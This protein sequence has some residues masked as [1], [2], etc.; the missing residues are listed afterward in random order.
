MVIR[1]L[2][3]DDSAFMRRLLTEMIKGFPGFEVAGIAKNG[4]EA[5][6]QVN[7]LKPD[8]VTLDVEMPIMDGLQALNEIMRTYPTPV[9][10]VS[11]LTQEG[12]DAT[13]Q[14]LLL[15]AVD[16]IGKPTG[17]ISLELVQKQE[18]LQAKLKAAASSRR[19]VRKWGVESPS[20]TTVSKP[21]VTKAPRLPSRQ[22]SKSITSICAIGTSTGGPKALETVI[23]SLP[24]ELDV[25]IV[26][27][28][29][30]PAK[31]TA[32]LAQRLNQLSK[33]HVMEASHHQRLEPGC[34]YIAPGGKHMEIIA[35]GMSDFR[36]MIQEQNAVNGHRPSVEVM[37][38]SV[39]R[40]KGLHKT[41]VI[42]TG[43]GADGAKAMQ[44]AKQSNPLA[45][46]VGEAE[47]TC[48]VYG[49]PRAAAELK[50]VDHVLPLQQISRKLLDIFSSNR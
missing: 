4:A 43:M 22:G 9:V 38:D 28:Q 14:A 5:V 15:G 33:V 39:T 12:A 7:M 16:F 27:V 40:L 26:I 46:T 45:V 50:C 13:I 30:M 44:R 36:I 3:V 25:P 32:S 1:V 11:S 23:R 24:E 2:I 8:V 10:M 42:M 48:I 31:F 20:A 49:M 18:E 21:A 37:F 19:S 17:S 47:S 35:A 34:V 6:E 41:Y 29:H